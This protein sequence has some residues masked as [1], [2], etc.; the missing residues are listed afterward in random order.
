MSL[1][2]PLGIFHPLFKSS[3]KNKHRKNSLR[4]SNFHY[5]MNQSLTHKFKHNYLSQNNTHTIN[6]INVFK[7]NTNIIFFKR[8]FIAYH[9]FFSTWNTPSSI[10]S[11]TFNF[12]HFHN[13]RPFIRFCV[14]LCLKERKIQNQMNAQQSNNRNRH[15][16]IK[17][18]H[19]FMF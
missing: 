4:K 15:V 12:S 13:I 7:S 19:R 2:F 18:Q 11:H 9:N 8:I 17:I 1:K 6:T 16:I 14:F 3:Y 10:S 5:D